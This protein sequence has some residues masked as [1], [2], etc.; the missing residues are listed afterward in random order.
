MH[1]IVAIKFAAWLNPHFEVWV[2]K[3]IDEILFAYSRE[4]DLSIQ[5]AVVLQH[6]L[7][8]LE[9]KADKNGIDFERFIKLNNELTHERT[10]RAASTK[11][12]FRE[13]YRDLKPNFPTN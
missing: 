5:R 12:R 10:I 2:Y 11:A 6:E 1:W 8:E 9:K 13:I 7:K 4:Q 3:T